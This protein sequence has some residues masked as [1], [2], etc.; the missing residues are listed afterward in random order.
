MKT[1]FLL[2]KVST[3]CAKDRKWYTMCSIFIRSMKT[4]FNVPRQTLKAK[5]GD[6]YMGKTVW[7]GRQWSEISPD[8]AIWSGWVKRRILVDI[9][10]YWLRNGSSA[11]LSNQSSWSSLPFFHSYHTPNSC[12]SR[13]SLIEKF[14]H[15][16]LVVLFHRWS[17]ED[18]AII[19][20]SFCPSCIE[21]PS[22]GC[23]SHPPQVKHDSFAR[24]SPFCLISLVTASKDGG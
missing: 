9:T 21:Y 15:H 20:S 24:Y 5:Q 7:Y 11:S 6:Y 13:S 8:L 3:I 17:W 23:R 12:R 1:Q 19:V 14:L 4:S 22:Q 18:I 16:H 2:N 10:S